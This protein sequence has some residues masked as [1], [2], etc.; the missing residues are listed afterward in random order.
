MDQPDFTDLRPLE[1]Q[2]RAIVADAFSLNRGSEGSE[3]D[4]RLLAGLL[5]EAR[6]PL[7]YTAFDGDHFAL[8][9]LMRRFVLSHGGLPVDPESILGYKQAVDAHQNKRDVLR[10]DLAV[11]TKCDELWVFTDAPATARGASAGLAEGVLAE[12]L[13][14]LSRRPS[15]KVSF[16]AI[17]ALF[18]ESPVFVSYTSTDTETAQAMAEGGMEAVCEFVTSVIDGRAPI[19]RICAFAIDSLDSKYGDWVRS[20]AYT[21]GRVPLIPNLALAVE[22]VAFDGSSRIP[23]VLLMMSWVGLLSLADELCVLM[24]SDGGRESMM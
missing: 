20:G 16:V 15:G 4:H 2:C 12:I 7:V 8:S 21:R 24:P 17:G 9:P 18:G 10:D 1:P 22:D 13:Y 6:Q 19:R 14:F 23:N 3:V 5:Q 11:L